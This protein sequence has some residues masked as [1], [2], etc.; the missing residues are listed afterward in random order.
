[1]YFSPFFFFFF[2]FVYSFFFLYQR[3]HCSR[4]GLFLYFE[5]PFFPPPDLKL[6]TV[7]AFL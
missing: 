1:M 2:E 3:V 5:A 7:F 4:E 6:M